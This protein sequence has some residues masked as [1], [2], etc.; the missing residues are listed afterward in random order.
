MDTSPY[1]NLPPDKKVRSFNR[2][3]RRAL[4]LYTRR[5]KA[6]R[7]TWRDILA[8]EFNEALAE[9]DPD[10]LRAELVQVAAVAVNWVEAIDRREAGE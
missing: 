9:S 2:A 4:G 1:R 5:F 10:R 6:G 7:G 8:E 3:A